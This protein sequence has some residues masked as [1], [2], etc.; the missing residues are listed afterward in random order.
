MKQERIWFLIARKLSNEITEAELQEL[1]CCL[2]NNPQLSY[3]YEVITYLWRNE[4][5]E[6]QPDTLPVMK[7]LKRVKECTDD[8]Y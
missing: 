2:K 7:L 6:N 8:I 3:S 1:D 5:A 4:N